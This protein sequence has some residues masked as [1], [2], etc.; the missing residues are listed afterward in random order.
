MLEFVRFETSRRRLLTVGGGSLGVL[1]GGAR[2]FGSPGGGPS[3]IRSCVVLVLYG[4]PSHIDT[5]DMK[6]DAPSEV[7]GEYRPIRTSVPGR[8]VC[9]HLPAC[10][11]I[12]DRMAVVRSVRHT[13]GDHNAAVYETLVGRPHHGTAPVAGVN[14][15]KDFPG[16]GSIVGWLAD[17]GQLPPTGP[18]ANVILPRPMRNVVE[19]PGQNAGF[20]PSRYDPL[21]VDADPNENDFRVR[22]LSF[23]PNVD[24]SRTRDRVQ[25]LDTLGGASRYAESEALRDNRDRALDLLNGNGVREAFRIDREPDDVRDAYGRTTLGQS[26]LLARR[27]VEAGV[28]FVNVNDGFTNGQQANWDSHLAIFPRHRELL[29][30]ADRAI[31]TFVTDLEDRGLLDSTLVLVTGEFGRTPKVNGNAGRDHWPDCYSV[32]LAGGGVRGGSTYGASDGTGAYPISR[33][34][35][36][37]DLAA[38]LFW[39]FGA[40]PE[41]EIHDRLGRPFPLATGQPLHDLFA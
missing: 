5:W 11:R 8:V 19:L 15:I 10:A 28:R 6:P 32:V 3:P 29:Q 9:E 22:N 12:L 33:A 2:G 31:A 7:R 36:P 30:P 41:T 40:N 35:S 26:M 27:L 21:R 4:G 16:H 23:P 39:R 1:L 24:T 20:A 38:T 17:H 34:V 14:R 37:A 18:L 25:L 13:H